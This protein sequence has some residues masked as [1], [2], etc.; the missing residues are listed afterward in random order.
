MDILNWLF[1]KASKLIRTKPSN[2]KSDLV[3][4]GADVTFLR[5]GD[6][7]KTYGMTLA[8]AVHG[9]C[10][11]NNTLYTGIY[12][13]F[14]FLIGYPVLL[15]TCTQV[16]DTPAFP[17]AVPINLQGWKVTGSLDIN[18]NA[19]SGVIYLGTIENPIPNVFSPYP[20]KINGTV[21]CYDPGNDLNLYTTLANGA[22]MYDDNGGITIPVNIRFIPDYFYGG[23]DI[24][25]QYDCGDP[26]AE[27]RGVV[28]FEFEFLQDLAYEPKFTYYP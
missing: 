10:T 28:S 3:V 20:W 17:T 5:R 22:T 6:S 11:E 2:P 23:F 16:I 15:K 9:G 13:N 19:D 12:D 26:T 14:P 1:L 27:L 21:Y 8:D 7:Y 24:Y 25:L 18:E 4:L